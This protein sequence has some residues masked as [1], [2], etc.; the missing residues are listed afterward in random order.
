MALE[1]GGMLAS[2]PTCSWAVSTAR[3]RTWPSPQDRCGQFE[4]PELHHAARLR[5][6]QCL[7]YFQVPSRTSMLG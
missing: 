2:L 1:V 3:P 7:V 4:T 5:S 6:H